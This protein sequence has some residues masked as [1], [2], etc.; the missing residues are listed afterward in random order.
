MK[1]TERTKQREAHH[2]DME[3]VGHGTKLF[4]GELLQAK[5][6]G[7]QPL[8]LMPRLGITKLPRQRN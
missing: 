7:S 6:L 3:V 2:T 8:S 1:F 5:D 4:S